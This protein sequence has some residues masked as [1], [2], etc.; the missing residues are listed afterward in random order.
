VPH[1]MSYSVAGLV[2]DF[3]PPGYPAGEPIVPHG[4]AV[5][6]NAPAV[7]RFTSSTSPDRHLEAARLLGADTRGAADADAG[8]ILAAR[9]VELMRATAMPNGIGGVGYGESDV[10]ALVAGA[11][12]QERLLANAPQPMSPE[13]LGATFRAALRYW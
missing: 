4:M 7:F 5:I 8:E 13:A 9:L 1:A 3:H 10:A 2:R 6:V 11:A 12:A